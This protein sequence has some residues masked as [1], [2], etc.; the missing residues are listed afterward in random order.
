MTNAQLNT[1]L[2]DSIKAQLFDATGVHLTNADIQI[3][4]FT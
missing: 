1:L 3:P 4:K 2:N